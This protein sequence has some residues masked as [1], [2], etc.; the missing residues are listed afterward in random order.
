MNRQRK[1]GPTFSYSKNYE[2]SNK[3]EI[4]RS[5]NIYDLFDHYVV[6][7]VHNI[8]IYNPWKN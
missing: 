6:S 8:L 7:K 1:R 4:S 2:T 3:H 5:P